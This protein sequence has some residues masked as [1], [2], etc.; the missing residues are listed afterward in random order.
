MSS[1]SYYQLAWAGHQLG[2]SCEPAFGAEAGSHRIASPE[3]D[4]KAMQDTTRPEGRAV[5]PPAARPAS[6]PPFPQTNHPAA[7]RWAPA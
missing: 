1:F 2:N 4:T 7:R 3:H 5:D 6:L